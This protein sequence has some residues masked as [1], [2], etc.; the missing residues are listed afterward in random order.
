MSPRQ[1]MHIG[2][3]SSGKKKKKITIIDSLVFLKD[4][5]NICH[6]RQVVLASLIALLVSADKDERTSLFNKQFVKIG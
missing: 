4:I 1:K 5:P 3:P 2:I 6:Q